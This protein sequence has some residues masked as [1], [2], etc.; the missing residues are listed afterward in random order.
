MATAVDQE[1]V[2]EDVPIPTVVLALSVQ[3]GGFVRPCL[4][5]WNSNRFNFGLSL[6]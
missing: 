4:R 3:T 5:T 6:P 1:A 2:S